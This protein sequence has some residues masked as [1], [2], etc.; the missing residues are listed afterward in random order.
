MNTLRQLWAAGNA[1]WEHS[2]PWKMEKGSDEFNVVM[3]TVVHYI[4]LVSVL[5]SPVIP[6]AAAAV[7]EGFG[8]DAAEATWPTDI[9]AEFT[10]FPTGHEVRA[11]GVLFTKLES[12]QLD[13]WRERFGGGA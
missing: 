9:A 4:R 3:L 13:A 10:R 7:L 11:P 2:Q 1:Y 8:E 6:R 5:A 12:E